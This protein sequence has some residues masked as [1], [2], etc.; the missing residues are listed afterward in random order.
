MAAAFGVM[1]LLA[2]DKTLA[3]LVSLF[4]IFALADGVFTMGAGFASNW[5]TLF[6]EGVVGGAVGLL[7]S[8]FFPVIRSDAG[9]EEGNN[10][11]EEISWQETGLLRAWP[12]EGR[13][14]PCRA[15]ARARNR[16]SGPRRNLRRSHLST[17]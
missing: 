9:Q 16:L 13:R 8:I 11:Q 7:T 14:C 17:S 5:F 10:S 15:S 2:P 12:H 6:L 1:A 4:G 3:F